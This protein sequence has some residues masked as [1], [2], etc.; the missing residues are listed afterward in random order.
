[1]A[2][3]WNDMVP[4]KIPSLTL[5]S[6]LWFDDQRTWWNDLNETML[7]EVASWQNDTV[8]SKTVKFDWN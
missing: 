2:S 6:F 3:W 1:M 4:S 8:P 7:D 5:N